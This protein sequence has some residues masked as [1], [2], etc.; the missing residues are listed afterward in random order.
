MGSRAVTAPA[1][2][3]RQLQ[4]NCCFSEPSQACTPRSKFPGSST[5]SLAIFLLRAQ[6]QNEAL[7]FEWPWVDAYSRGARLV[8]CSV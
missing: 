5:T 3:M 1:W 8:G 6:Q 4:A 7:G 2:T